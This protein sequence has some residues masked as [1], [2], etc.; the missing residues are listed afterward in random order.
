MKIA[1]WASPRALT[2][3]PKGVCLVLDVLRAT[4]VMLT[5]LENGAAWIR[6]VSET[7]EALKL[8]ESAGLGPLLGGERNA[9]KIPGFDFGN[10]PLEYTSERVAGRGIVMTTTNGTRAFGAC[11]EAEQV[12]AVCMRNA[13]S[14]AKALSR[15]TEGH[16]LCAGNAGRF[17][18]EDGL[19]A[20]A[21]LDKLPD[22]Q[23]DDLG[24][25]MLTLYR[26]H[27]KDLFSLLRTTAHT[28]RLLSLGMED[29]IRFCLEED[30]S[31]ALPILINGLL[32]LTAP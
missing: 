2:Q 28:G 18:L 3:P 14:G 10:S 12:Y 1:V 16:I 13:A 21:I 23:P 15:S 27:R 8:A 5:A 11:S 22:V 9:L 4:T 20:G 26:A 24:Q 17:T 19:C 32:N 29:D 7:E 6:P 30:A 31:S 25:A